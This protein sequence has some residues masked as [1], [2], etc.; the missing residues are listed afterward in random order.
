MTIYIPCFYL[1]KNSK[2]YNGQKKRDKGKNN[3][4]QNIAQKTKDRATQTPLKSGG[5]LLKCS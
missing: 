2:K 4:L 1:Q 5:E 3:D